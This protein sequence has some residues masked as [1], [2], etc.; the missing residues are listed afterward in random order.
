MRL[1][2]VAVVGG[3]RDGEDEVLREGTEELGRGIRTLGLHLVCGGGGGVME[4]VCRGFQSVPGPGRAIG[5]LPGS[6]HDDGNPFLDVA[7]PTGLGHGRNVLV[8]HAGDALVVVGGE[9]GTLSELAL[10][11]K[12][13][14]PVA[15]LVP[16]G[17]FGAELAGRRLDDR[18]DDTVFPAPTVAAVL[19]WLAAV[20]RP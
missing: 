11:W 15:A 16:A 3:G 20:V 8:A 19:D 18:R 4:A 10:A 17:G 9:S 12:L 5:I 13:G 2:A 7:L 6:R 14:R 1:R